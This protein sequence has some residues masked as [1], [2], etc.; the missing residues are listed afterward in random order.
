MRLGVPSGHLDLLDVICTATPKNNFLFCGGMLRQGLLVCYISGMDLRRIDS[1]TTPFLAGALSAHPWSAYRN[2][3]SNELFPTLVTGVDPTEHGVWGV[4]FQAGVDTNRTRIANCLPDVLVTGIQCIRHAL[5]PPFDLAAMPPR[6]RSRLQIKRTKY[7]RR[8]RWPE[9]LYRIGGVPTVLELVGRDRSRY[10]YSC[11]RDP[12][13]RLLPALPARDLTLEIVE[14]YS[15]DR[16]QQ[17]NLDRLDQVLGYYRVIDA[18]LR[19]LHAKCRTQGKILMVLSDHGHEPI[20]ESIDLLAALRRNGLSENDYTTFIEVSNA[21]FWLHSKKAQTKVPAILTELGH[22]TVFPYRGMER[23]GIPLRD[24]S[25]G[26]WFCFLDPGFIFFP[27]DFYHPVANIILGLADTMQRSRLRNPRHRGNHG[28]LPHFE[29]ERSFMLLLDSRYRFDAQETTIL[30][31]APS[32]LGVL[33]LPPSPFMKG[34][35]VFRL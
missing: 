14:L 9:A 34:R 27:H 12:M 23:Y 32:I 24:S 33:G 22:G 18:F 8:R 21:R 17:W 13:S 15:L 7:K 11:A 28:H 29:A 1:E 25:H 19:E 35:P 6:R 4:Q 30:D 2:L 10:V 31:V 16:F 3:P 5:A 20:R 26:E